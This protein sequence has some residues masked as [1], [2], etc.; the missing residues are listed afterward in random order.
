MIDSKD[1]FVQGVR[2]YITEHALLSPGQRVIVGL[3]GG[4]DSVALLAALSALGYHCIAAH[5]NFHLRGAESQRDMQH[6]RHIADKLNVEFS[7]CNFNTDDFARDNGMSI[8]MAARQQRYS[9]FTTLLE[10]E[11]AHAIAVAH[12]RHDQAETFFLNLLRGTGIKGLAGMS[13]R[14]GLVIRPLLDMS[15][16]D[17]TEFLSR[18]Q[19]DYVVDS[20]NSDT[21]FRRNMLRHETLP[22]LE[23]NFPGAENAILRTMR[24]LSDTLALHNIAVRKLCNQ[25]VS[26]TNTSQLQVDI[27]GIKQL[28]GNAASALLHEILYPYGFNSTQCLNILDSCSG[29]SFTSD[30]AFATHNRGKLHVSPISQSKPPITETPVS[31]THGIT[32]PVHIEVSRHN[33]AEFSPIRDPNVAYF[34]SKI[35]QDDAKFAIRHWKTGD[36]IKPF[37]MTGSRLVSDILSEKKMSTEQKRETL[38]LTR[39]NTIIWLP[40]IRASACYPVTPNTRTYL[41]L[42]FHHNK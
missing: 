29:A 38:V 10:R 24:N 2:R 41:R 32:N 30:S 25:Y 35:L 34:D 6:A 28:P 1:K 23:T 20:S 11:Q 19:L 14:N 7:Y 22:Q 27:D 5:C 13:A 18:N 26:G 33:I 17:I 42:T 9:W 3:S 4:A 40:G 12:H 36:R 37:G 39:N 15:R 31:L 16:T 8:E 21:K